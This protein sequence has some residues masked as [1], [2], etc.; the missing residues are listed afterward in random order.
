MYG[1]VLEFLKLL[2]Q[3]PWLFLLDIS[4]SCLIMMPSPLC[5]KLCSTC[6]A[7]ALV[8]QKVLLVQRKVPHFSPPF[9]HQLLPLC[10]PVFCTF[11]LNPYLVQADG[12]SH[13]TMPRD[14]QKSVS[15][16]EIYDHSLES[17]KLYY[18]LLHI[19]EKILLC[20][21]LYLSLHLNCLLVCFHFL[22]GPDTYLAAIQPDSI[23]PDSDF[24]YIFYTD[25]VSLEIIGKY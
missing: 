13:N 14:L 15:C 20:L 10:Y 8:T 17:L 12:F 22:L 7:S 4:S 19:I 6:C 21:Q 16:L 11:S 18:I 24:V 25:E 2:L 23:I 1:F 3:V 5:H 9:Q